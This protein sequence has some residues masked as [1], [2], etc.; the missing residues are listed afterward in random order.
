MLLVTPV[1]I[2]AQLIVLLVF[3]IGISLMDVVI[4]FVQMDI[5]KMISQE[6][7]MPFLDLHQ[8]PMIIIHPYSIISLIISLV[9]INLLLSL[10]VV[11]LI[12]HHINIG[13]RI[14]KHVKYVI[15]HVKNV[16]VVMKYHVH[17][18]GLVGI[19]LIINVIIHHLVVKVEPNISSMEIVLILVLTI[20]P[21]IN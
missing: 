11:L 12:V 1:L 13:I 4:K 3:V 21:L 20:P 17:H 15:H 2:L 14:I 10:L 8:L 16:L 19:F 9:K 18:V 5:V 6:L 7:V